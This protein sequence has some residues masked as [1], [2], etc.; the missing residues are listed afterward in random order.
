MK[1]PVNLPCELARMAVV[2]QDQ[3]KYEAAEEMNRR[4][5]EGRE[6]AGERAPRHAN[7]RKQPGGRVVVSGKVRSGRGDEPANMRRR[8]GKSTLP[9]WPVYTAWLSFFINSNNTKL[10]RHYIKGQVADTNVH[11]AQS[12]LPLSSLACSKHYSS[13]MQEMQYS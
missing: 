12:I 11:L 10:L 6:G 13:L 2:L 5:L 4:A 3:G 9:R 8:W 1:C 7:Q